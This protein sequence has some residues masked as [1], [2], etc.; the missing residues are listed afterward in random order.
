MLQGL[1]KSPV[2]EIRYHAEG[3]DRFWAGLDIELHV[4]ACPPPT[5]LPFRQF[6]WFSHNGGRYGLAAVEAGGVGSL[7]ES[8]SRG[9]GRRGPPAPFSW[10]EMIELATKAKIGPLTH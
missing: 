2:I 1:A 7:A 8:S 6:G 4:A 9:T 5:G 10:I 3:L